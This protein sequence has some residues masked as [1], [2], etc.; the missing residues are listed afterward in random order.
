[1]NITNIKSKISG[2]FHESVYINEIDIY[3]SIV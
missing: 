3:G 2:M 1:M